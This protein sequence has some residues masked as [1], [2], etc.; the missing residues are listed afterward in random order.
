MQSQWIGSDLELSWINPTTDGNWGEVDQLRIVAFDNNNQTVL[1]IRLAADNTSVIIPAD[2][3][4]QSAMLLGGACLLSGRS[5]P[6]PMTT[7]A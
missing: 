4:S 1:Q 7:T 2:L 6:S 5:R 3:V